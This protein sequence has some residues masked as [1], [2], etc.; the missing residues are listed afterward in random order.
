ME[1]RI[2]CVKAKSVGV[3][4]VT[5]PVEHF[6]DEDLGNVGPGL[7]FDFGDMET[8]IVVGSPAALRAF[9]QKA[10]DALPVEL[11]AQE[12]SYLTHV[13]NT[14]DYDA[15][16]G[17]IGRDPAGW[18]WFLSDE[19]STSYDLTNEQRRELH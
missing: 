4:H 9:L 7:A 5:D 8:V 12:E 13:C 16:A 15:E 17:T 11:T 1:L 14:Y 6:E 19:D 18:A 3:E 10:L 2:H